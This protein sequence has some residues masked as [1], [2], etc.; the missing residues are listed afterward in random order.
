MNRLFCFFISLLFCLTSFA[1]VKNYAVAF[2]GNSDIKFN[3][4]SE[5]NNLSKYTVQFWMYPSE[6]TPG[7]SIFKR[8]AGADI[9]EACL[10]PA[11]G[12]IVFHI[13]NQNIQLQSDHFS[14]SA[15][16][17][18][19]F[20]V[21]GS[22]ITSYVNGEEINSPTVS[23]SLTIPDSDSEFRIGEAFKGKIDEFRLWSTVLDTTEYLTHDPSVKGF[24]LWDNTINKFHPDYE[25]LIAYYKFDQE[26]CD[27]IV[28]YT[29][30]HHGIMN[31]NA[32][33]VEVTDN[34]FF[35]Y[36][37]VTAYTDFGRFSD[38][39]TDRDKYLLCNDLVA[40][41]AGIGSDGSASV[42]LPFDRGVLTGGAS[43]LESYEGRN[44]G[45]LA[46]DGTGKMSAGV[47]AMTPTDDYSFCTW[48]Y[49]DR[50]VEGAFLLKKEKN[51]NMGI[52]LRLGEESNAEVI[53][54]VNGDE[55]KYKCAGE[56]VTGK[57]IHL[58]F[59]TSDRYYELNRTFLFACNKKKLNIYPYLYPEI[60]KSWVLPLA[61]LADVEATI[62]ENF[63]GKIDETIIWNKG[64][65]R[66]E[67][68]SMGD[69]GLNLPGFGKNVGVNY[70]FYA[71]S[72]WPYNKPEDPGYDCFSYKE[73]LNIMRTAYANHRG[74]KIRLSVSSGSD[75]KTV[76]GNAAKRERFTT[77]MADI[78][79]NDDNL[80]GVDFD[81]EW[82]GY[83]GQDA[84]WTNYGK[85]MTL[86][87]S[88]LKEGKT[89]T[90][91]PHTVSYWFP[92][93]D[94]KS[95]DYFL[96]QNYGPAKEHFT[97]E[98]FPEAYN[99]FLAW[100]YPEEKIVMSFAGSTS[101]Q[102]NADGS[103]TNNPS[104]R[105]HQVG[106]I[107]PD[108]NY[109]NGYYFTGTYQTRWRS[110][111]VKK[112]G[113][114]GIMCWS[115]NIDFPDT[116]HPLSLFK[117][118]A[119]AISSNVDTL[120]TKVDMTPTA[121]EKVKTKNTEFSIYPNP[122]EGV[123]DITIPEGEK[124]CKLLMYTNSGVLLQTLEISAEGIFRYEYGK[125]ASGYYLLRL[126]TDSGKQYS[127]LLIV[128]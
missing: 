89:L 99:K 122:S 88:K 27:N 23:S 79:N 64:S 66:D 97:Y 21:D 20:M 9:F 116:N 39:G 43:Y 42:S 5:L 70:A 95:V 14:V 60:K 48:F 11:E 4:I 6:W 68:F 8:G 128:K 98:S 59:S 63:V 94:M 81:L 90:V 104:V 37:I 102:Y 125:L 58:G 127:R 56:I 13:G 92:K 36:R 10:G 107:G 119:Y 87:R 15:W 74:F 106:E 25:S 86:L 61:E 62:G 31:G 123:T 3:C 80:D 120:V 117:S 44:G 77:E 17:Q 35:K 103:Q 72:Y 118:S 57:W 105:I 40:L 85:L 19:T 47:K 30:R 12:T 26:L 38:T 54:R 34:S 124:G 75:W 84:A 101:K 100:E 28:D 82:P 108:D 45:M 16:S 24:I 112:Q 110:E 115:L 113:L 73:Y 121:I 91:S 7:A 32:H 65:G 50:W 53:L 51:E 109:S 55:Y 41:I 18:L 1:Q 78:I 111:Q 67:I 96:F 22:N 2:D 114:G 52:S 83:G 126:L 29:F 76:I 49:I 93:E 69:N 71:G 46:F 33:R